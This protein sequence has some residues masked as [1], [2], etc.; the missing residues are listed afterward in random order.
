MKKGLSVV[1]AVCLFSIFVL[2]P[3]STMAAN[4][5]FLDA[6]FIQAKKK[7]PA[8]DFTLKDLEGRQVQLSD[9]KGNVIL[10][11]FWTTW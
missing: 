4:D 5:P 10:L 6:G 11:Y 2:A 8:L 3:I 9:F 1:T 7:A